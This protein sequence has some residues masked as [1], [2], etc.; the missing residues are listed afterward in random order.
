MLVQIGAEPVNCIDTSMADWQ[1]RLADRAKVRNW[2]I[3]GP[4]ILII[5]IF[6]LL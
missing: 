3:E 2:G 5:I 6:F 1:Q 4:N